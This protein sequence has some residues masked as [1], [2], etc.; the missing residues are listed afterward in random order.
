MSQYGHGLAQVGKKLFAKGETE[1]M[2]L[3]K[4]STLSGDSWGTL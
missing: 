2:G 1:I 4:I 3:V